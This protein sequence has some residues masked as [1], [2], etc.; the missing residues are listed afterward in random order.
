MACYTLAMLTLVYAFNYFDRS[1]I[2]ILL[3]QIQADIHISD[4]VM[5]LIAGAAF[6]LVNAIMGIPMAWLAD[7]SN[8]RNI[9]GLGCIFW[10]AMTALTGFTTNVWQFAT[11]RF[12]MGAGEACGSA[13]STSLLSDRFTPRQRPLALAVM[14]S[15]NAL[16][17]LILMPIAGWIGHRHGWQGAYWAAG[18]A[19]MVVGLIFLLT[20]REPPRVSSAAAGGARTYSFGDAFRYMSGQRSYVWM[21]LAGGL[22]SVSLSG[23]L[24]W[25][26]AFLARV[27]SFDILQV[28]NILGPVR[29]TMTLIGALAAGSLVQ[30]LSERD[31]RWRVWLPALCCTLTLPAQLLFLFA[32]SMELS[33]VGLALESLLGGTLVPLLFA[34]LLNLAPPRL[35]AFAVSVY[36]LALGVFGQ[37][38]GPGIVG[39]LNDLLAPTFGHLSIR[40]SMVVTASFGLASG[41]IFWIASANYRLDVQRAEISMIMRSPCAIPNFVTKEIFA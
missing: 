15:G 17:G 10:S 35:R 2:S 29:G 25:A 36:L 12:L 6:V 19:G 23:H 31:Q 30:R 20:V 27:H 14:T 32:G 41:L 1:L 37:V 5:G 38:L 33:I 24:I 9:I 13:P 4:T 18:I 26:A 22:A 21:I 11:T 39:Y 28:A 34:V 40:Y 16:G 3:P 7:R 8:R